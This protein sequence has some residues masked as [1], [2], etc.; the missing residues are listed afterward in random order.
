[1][2]K[3]CTLFCRLTGSG[4][5][6][7]ATT[8]LWGDGAADVLNS[9]FHPKGKTTPGTMDLS[10]VLFGQ[11]IDPEA[12][13]ETGEDVVVARTDETGFVIHGHGG[14]AAV[15]RTARIFSQLGAEESDVE[16]W[17]I[18]Q[19]VSEENRKILAMLEQA[20]TYR[21]ASILLD[22][23]NG[24]GRR[25]Q[26]RIAQLR[27]DGK[28]AQAQELE[29][30]FYETKAIARHLLSPWRVVFSGRPNV[31]KSSL[32][33]AI[34]GF[35]RSIVNAQQGTTRDLV[36][37]QTTIDGWLFEFVD[38]AGIRETADELERE[39]VNRAKNAIAK[40]DLVVRLFDDADS[41]TTI[42][43]ARTIESFRVDV[44]TID[45]MNK[46]DLVATPQTDE[47]VLRV[48]AVDGAGIETLLQ[49]IVQTL[50]PNPPR[51]GEGVW[52][53]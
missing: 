10:A 48:S 22:Q 36:Q 9:C 20:P 44:P 25:T 50:V 31:G 6:A 43:R 49:A 15:A 40:A 5:G 2:S 19:N 47:S 38:A 32:L 33:N 4:P 23:Y 51:P 26:E 37:A 12:P 29:K 52:L 42:E 18:H 21:T 28:D 7:L 30:R 11:L 14:A 46:C 39:G 1:M 35:Q 13:E 17:R 8:A 41:M 45:V 3:P 27:A 34:L 53:E 24:A 16:R